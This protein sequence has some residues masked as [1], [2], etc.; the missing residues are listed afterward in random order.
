EARSLSLYRA[1]IELTYGPVIALVEKRSR[2]WP[3]D[4][5]DEAAMKRDA[6]TAEIR[7]LRSSPDVASAWWGLDEH[8]HGARSLSD[9]NCFGLSMNPLYR[10]ADFRNHVARYGKTS[11]GKPLVILEGAVGRPTIRKFQT[12]FLGKARSA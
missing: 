8:P 11:D 10:T 3:S 1:K 9:W 6:V 7:S 2:E 4:W 5:S 12:P